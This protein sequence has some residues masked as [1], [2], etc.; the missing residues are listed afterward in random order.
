MKLL[1]E[2]VSF[3]ETDKLTDAMTCYVIDSLTGFVT[4]TVTH[5]ENYYDLLRYWLCDWLYD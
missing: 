1:K 5:S 3:T 4:D 2:R